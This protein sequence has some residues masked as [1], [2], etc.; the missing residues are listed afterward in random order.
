MAKASSTL[1]W[2][3]AATLFLA[4]SSSHAALARRHKGGGGRSKP[5]A[6]TTKDGRPNVQAYGAMVVDLDSGQE[7]YSKNADD[8]RFIASTTKIF[9]AMVVRAKGIDLNAETVITDDDQQR[10]R[11]GA[12]SRLLVG[13][14]FKNG[15]LLR[16]MLIGSD[17]RACSALARGAGLSPDQLIDRM[18]QLARQLGLKKTKFTDTSGLHGNESTP[19]E[20]TVAL[21]E[22]LTDPLLA[23]I[24]STREAE[25]HAVDSGE[26]TTK[27]KREIKKSAYSIH[28]NN[29]NVSLR[30]SKFSVVGGK[31]GYTDLARYCLVIATKIGG[32]RYA[33]SFLGAEGELTRFADFN[34]VCEWIESGKAVAQAAARGKGVG[35]LADSPPAAV[36]PRLSR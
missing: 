11:G 4:A 16:A 1:I 9:V 14:R 30:T 24:M 28:Y 33:M 32:H 31:T 27:G 20:M 34:R 2:T 12:K 21:R 17:N 35:S 10:A 36:I 7:L 26:V 25:I 13:R 8:L 29:T 19:R 15:D 22:A 3:L 23:E 6:A 5:I 18:N